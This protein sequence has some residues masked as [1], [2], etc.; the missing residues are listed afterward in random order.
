MYDTTRNKL[1]YFPPINIEPSVLK[2]MSVLIRTASPKRL[3]PKVTI[4]DRLL[5]FLS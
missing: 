3:T 2:K 4:P 1:K 5:V